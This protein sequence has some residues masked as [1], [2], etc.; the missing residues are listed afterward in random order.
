MI[1]SNWNKLDHNQKRMAALAAG[2]GAIVLVVIVAGG[3]NEPRER[4]IKRQDAIRSVLT[5]Q[6]NRDMSI[7]ALS[8]NMA[9]AQRENT[10]LQKNIEKIQKELDETKEEG[11][12]NATL[13][14]ELK[15]LRKELAKLKELSDD[16]ASVAAS[17]AK[18][19]S[20]KQVIEAP[21]DSGGRALPEKGTAS[22][23]PADSS[24]VFSEI[25][26][27]APRTNPETGEYIPLKIVSHVQPAPQK[28]KAE[29]AEEE[30]YMPAASILSGVLLNG[31]DAPTGKG[32][33]KDPFPVA[34]RIQ[35]E[36][37]LPNHYRAD[38]RECFSLASGYG[39]LSTERAFLRTEVI[40]CVRDD[41]GIIEARLKGYVV[42]E[43][44]KAGLRGR[45]V[46]KQGQVIAKSLMAGFAS[47][48]AGA[49]DVNPVPVINTS[50][51]G[52]T[53]YQKNMNSG[54]LQGAAMKGTSSALDRVA[55]FYIDMAESMFPVVEVDAGR[56]ADIIITGGV[57]LKILQ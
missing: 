13:N 33:R 44:G 3:D 35:K 4:V 5:D 14:K 23:Y 27:P 8:A 24:E 25:D 31:L 55:Q 49:F 41:G 37:I 17:A 39:D 12:T 26:A 2:L 57:K 47:G 42:G 9:I 36:A 10:K 38:V 43:D 7:D 11:V 51:S 45:L 56:P 54:M 1:K 18:K 29:E 34:I 19:A 21:A 16:N 40:S 28:K 46:S 48:A 6:N 32:A 52:K 20:E 15:L 22:L 50:P 30:V 53:D